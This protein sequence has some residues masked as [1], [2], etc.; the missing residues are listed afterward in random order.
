MMS[1]SRPLFGQFVSCLLLLSLLA[2]GTTASSSASVLAQ[3]LPDDYPDKAVEFVVPFSPGGG[4]DNF[5]RTIASML[6]S[7]GIVESPINVVNREGGGGVIG[8]TY[9]LGKD[10]DDYVLMTVTTSILT[11]PLILGSED[12]YDRYS[13]I[14]RLALD[15]LLII[16]PKDSEFE[17]IEDLIEA[18]KATPDE[19]SWGGSGLGGEDSLLLAQI[20]NESGANLNYISFESGGE[21]QAALLGGHIDVASAN[22][23]E[24]LGQLEAGD[25]RALAVAGDERLEALPDVPTMREKG[26]DAVYQQMR[27]VFGPPDMDPAAVQYWADA[28]QT[29]SE[30]EQWQTEYI[31]ENSL[32]SA[33]LPPDEFRTF[34]DEE[35]AAFEV[36]IDEMGVGVE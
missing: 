28:L 19:V 11:N 3:D 12:R 35:F 20:E 13:P 34:L 36:L 6:Q 21:V 1:R 27:G 17:T 7:Q 24:I 32:R 9:V 16:V 31:D 18:G 2:V 5:S 23:N 29:L 4:S 33:Y 25:I 26:V 30:S 8:G 22:P 15:Q 10:G 14:A